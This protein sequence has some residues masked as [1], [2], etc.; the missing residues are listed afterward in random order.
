MALHLCLLFL[1]FLHFLQCF[2]GLPFRF[3][4]RATR[5]LQM[6]LGATNHIPRLM[7]S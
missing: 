1:L 4:T 5:K 2:L 3:C 6:M 7:V